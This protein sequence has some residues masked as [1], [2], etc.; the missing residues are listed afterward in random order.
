MLHGKSIAVGTGQRVGHGDPVT[1]D[2]AEG[3]QLSSAGKLFL[4]GSP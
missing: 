4:R 3:K 1:N 2:Q